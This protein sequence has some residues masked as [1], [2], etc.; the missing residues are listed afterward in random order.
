MRRSKKYR[1]QARDC[2][3]NVQTR[4]QVS[5]HPSCPPF[6][7]LLKRF[8][9]LGASVNLDLERGLDGCALKDR[10]DSMREAGRELLLLL[11]LHASCPS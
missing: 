2:E 10:Q 1:S 6:A 5:T 9:D 4:R 8:A 7:A 11:G 3:G